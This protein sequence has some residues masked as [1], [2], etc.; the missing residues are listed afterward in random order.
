MKKQ[1][2]WTAWRSDAWGSP[3]LATQVWYGRLA[4]SWH[5]T[6]SATGKGWRLVRSRRRGQLRARTP[7][8]LFRQLERVGAV[9]RVFDSRLNEWVLEPELLREDFKVFL[10]RGNRIPADSLENALWMAKENYNIVETPENVTLLTRPVVVPVE[11]LMR[12]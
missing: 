1:I 8:G 11:E 7:A 2:Y 9:R 10:I 5:W 4:L 6:A 12:L 3:Y